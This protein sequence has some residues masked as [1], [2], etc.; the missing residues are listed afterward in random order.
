M[1]R[2]DKVLA[3]VRMT[4]SLMLLAQA[5][6]ESH[7]WPRILISPK[8]LEPSV[9]LVSC[10]S[11]IPSIQYISEPYATFKILVE[12]DYSTFTSITLVRGTI[13]SC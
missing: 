11:F 9:T 5:E 3:R 10:P 2:V 7:S 8:N 4:I 1:T 6:E 12:A 13:I